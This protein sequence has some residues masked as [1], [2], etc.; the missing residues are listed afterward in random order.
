MAKLID[1]RAS[2]K[3]MRIFAVEIAELKIKGVTPGPAV[4]F[5]R[6]NPRRAY[7]SKA[8]VP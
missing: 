7:G 8:N 6:D 1:G 2:G 4:W 3:S 5:C